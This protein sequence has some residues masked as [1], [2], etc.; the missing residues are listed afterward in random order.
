METTVRN[1]IVS[2]L[3]QIIEIRNYYILNTKA[4]FETEP[5]SFQERLSWF[6][7]YK[8]QGPYQIWVAD[9][10]D[11]ILGYAFSSPYRAGDYFDR[12]IETSIYLHPEAKG[13]GIGSLLYTHLFEELKNENLVTAVAGIALPNEASV[14][15]HKKFGFQEVGIFKNYAEKNGKLISSLWLQKM[16]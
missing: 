15:L 1:A 7:R 12:T 10:D 4:L 6:N 9:L 11:K 8:N 13:Q 16:F 2:D 3:P 5:S 14:A